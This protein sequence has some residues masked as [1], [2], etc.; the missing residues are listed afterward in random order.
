MEF[1]YTA[2]AEENIAERKLSKTL[3]EGTVLYP[4]RITV[5]RLGR[6]IAQK[7]IEGKLLR[8]VYE[9]KQSVYI[10]ITAYYTYLERYK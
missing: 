5:S 4:E 1:V 8:V 2:H 7:V 10:I 9:E 3:I 6:R